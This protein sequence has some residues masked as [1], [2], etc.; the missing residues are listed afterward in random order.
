MLWDPRMPLKENSLYFKPIV[1]LL[2]VT[3][4]CQWEKERENLVQH[5]ANSKPV[6][7]ANE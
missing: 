4:C 3:K 7:N 2:E 5:R 6:A 1:L